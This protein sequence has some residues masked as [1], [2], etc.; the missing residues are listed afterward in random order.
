MS[1]IERNRR[2]IED[3][4]GDSEVSRSGS[5][6][7]VLGIRVFREIMNCLLIS[8]A[9]FESISMHLGYDFSADLHYWVKISGN[10]SKLERKSAI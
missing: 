6:P 4:V 2:L 7:M 3:C 8:A 1:W 9:C 5:M 10:A